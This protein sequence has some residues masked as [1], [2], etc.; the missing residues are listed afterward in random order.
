AWPKGRLAVVWAADEQPLSGVVNMA[1]IK[2]GQFQVEYTLANGADGIEYSYLDRA[3][4]EAKTLRVP[5]P[6]VTTMLNPAQVTGE[7]VTSEAHAAMLAR[8]HLAQSLYQYKSISYSTDIEHLA[9]G[10][11]SV[12]ALQHDLTQWGFG[13][14]VLS[15]SMGPGRVVTLQLD[16]PVPAPAQ[17]SAYIGLRIPGERVYRVLRVVP[18][19]GESDRLQLAE[20]WPTDAELPGNSD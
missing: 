5:A 3:T 9:Y 18:F 17:G 16:V 1:T 14:Q 4:W 19:T 15:A 6:G 20:P 7:G 11:M 8:W 12:L 10:R 13:G 2:K